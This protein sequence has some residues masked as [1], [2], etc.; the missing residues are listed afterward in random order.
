MTWLW[1]LVPLFYYSHWPNTHLD[2]EASPLHNRTPSLPLYLLLA[3]LL[4]LLERKGEGI[5]CVLVWCSR[6]LY[7]HMM[8][9]EL[10]NIT[11]VCVCACVRA[12]V[13]VCIT[14]TQPHSIPLPFYLLL[15]SCYVI[16]QY[17]HPFSKVNMHISR[18]LKCEACPHLSTLLSL[19][20]A[21]LVIAWK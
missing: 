5:T 7:I 20:P 6:Q 17:V 3:S 12:C 11:G 10:C 2:T 4:V 16:A 19:L 21:C 18:H 9:V 13:H 8:D 1:V 15:A 14:I